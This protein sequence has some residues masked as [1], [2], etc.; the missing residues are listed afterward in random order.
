MQSEIGIDGRNAGRAQGTGVATYAEVLAETY[1]RLGMTPHWI[2]DGPEA[3]AG[4]KLSPLARLAAAG[5]PVRLLR[6]SRAAHQAD[7]ASYV[8][9]LFRVAHVRFRLTG[10]M[11]RLRMARPPALMHWT[12]PLPLFLEGTRNVVTIHDLIPLR[13]PELTG[14][15]AARMRRL[16]QMILRHASGIVTVSETVRQE[17]VE[18]FGIDPLR[19]ANL[20]QAV[21]GEDLLASATGGGGEALCPPGSFVAIGSV[22]RRKNIGRLI[23]AHGRSGTR[24]PLAIIGPDS[25]TAGSE[26]EALSAHPHPE[27][28]LRVAWSDRPSLLR[29]LASARALL[30]PTLA[31]GFGLPIPEAMALGVPVL[32]SRGGAT[33]EIAGGAAFLV[34]PR[35]PEDIAR[36]IRRLDLDDMLAGRLI[37]AARARAAFFS[38]DAYAVRLAAFH[39]STTDQPLS[40]GAQFT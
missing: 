23:L 6:P 17:I 29:T 8:P 18:E 21:R 19:I 33:E 40:T 1:R 30:F 10:R 26:M 31:E 24:R 32:T 27:R 37:V 2:G 16:L 20:Y 25:E 14:I 39:R 34:D 3:Q 28:V 12:Y 4:P 22:G 9:D 36:G 11:L 35:D 38:V 7:G 13:Q 15:P 5:R